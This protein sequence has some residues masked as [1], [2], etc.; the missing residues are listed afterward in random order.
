MHK[1]HKHKIIIKK[2][3]QCIHKQIKSTNNNKKKGERE[4]VESNVVR[5]KN[6]STNRWR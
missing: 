5:T 6:I 2:K 1:K 3:Q 4:D